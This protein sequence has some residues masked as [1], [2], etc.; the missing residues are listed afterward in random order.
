ML[1]ICLALSF[2]TACA[3]SKPPEIDVCIGDGM[4]GADCALKA[5]SPLRGKCLEFKS[6]F[7]CPPSTLQN[8]F[9][10]TPEDMKN[11]S[12]WCYHAH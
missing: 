10:T 8:T 2:E 6:G 5:T 4:G 11:F 3:T 12:S 1:W 7:Y 9:I